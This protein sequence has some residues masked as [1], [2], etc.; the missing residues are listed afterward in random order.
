MLT[1]TN[2]GPHFMKLIAKLQGDEGINS[3][4]VGIANSN[5]KETE[6]IPNYYEKVIQILYILPQNL[7]T[8]SIKAQNNINTDSDI[9][10]AKETEFWDNL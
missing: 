1:N 7:N 6:I 2:V 5:I 4:I 8:P 3:F 10:E 9:D